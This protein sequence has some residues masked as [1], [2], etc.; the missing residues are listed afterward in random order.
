MSQ[1][2][3]HKAEDDVKWNR[4]S[5]AGNYI[6]G[7]DG[8][9]YA[10]DV[11]TGKLL[12]KRDDL[13]KVADSSVEEVPGTP[14]IFVAQTEG[15]IM[16][17]AKLSAI[18]QQSGETVWS[19]EQLR[20]SVVDLI[21]DYQHNAMIMVI[22]GMLEN[23]FGIY[24]ESF[25]LPTGK[26]RWEVPLGDKADLYTAE[27]SGRFMPKMDLSGH[28]TPIID[29]HHLYLPYAGL[30]K[31]DL[32]T[33]KLVWKQKFD[34]TEKAYKKTNASPMV[35]GNLVYTSA[36]G[37][38]LAFDKSSG[39]PKW[40]SQDY[41][42]AIP[43]MI[44]AEGV[45]YGRMG[46]TF[47]SSGAKGFELKKPLGVVALDAGSGQMKWRFDDAKEGITNFH[48]DKSSNLILLADSKK[49]FGLS[50]N[51]SGNDV[52]AAFQVPLEFKFK[53]SKGKAIA[54]G[55]GKFAMGGLAAVAKKDKSLDDPPI[56]MIGRPDGTVVV[57]GS[58]HLLKFDPRT[59]KTIYANEFR[60]PGASNWQKFNTI[61]AFAM[62]YATSTARAASSYAG[63]YEN[64]WANHDRQNSI[65]SL[66]TNMQKRY[67]ASMAGDDFAYILSDIENEDGKGPGILGVNLDSGEIEKDALIKDREPLFAV[68]EVTG[69]LIRTHKGKSEITGHKL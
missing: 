44:H 62:T 66:F 47:A 42:A 10:L 11:T 57:R 33:G 46:G 29:G 21:P 4:V 53:Q 61:A 58:N 6:Y 45:I 24:L 69:M 2:W 43:E 31:F 54:K 7:T 68:D 59:R 56:S 16:T 51:G 32:E 3:S 23:K 8:G 12:W 52:K 40:S 48:Y 19:S 30:H 1:S 49:L 60:A 9:I 28:A 67:K 63:T 14:V 41:G 20:G 36:K 64:T 17:K 37:K 22:N 27:N 25:E 18:N 13:K 34:V 38:I 5:S 65:Q 55:M 50:L 15:A 35:V 39:K 26:L